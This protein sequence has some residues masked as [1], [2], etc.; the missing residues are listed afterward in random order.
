[1][2]HVFKRRSELG[3]TSATLRSDR[4]KKRNL[5]CG[6]DSEVK[7]GE[8]WRSTVCLFPKKLLKPRFL[9]GVRNWVKRRRRRREDGVD[10]LMKCATDTASI[11][12]GNHLQ[13][14]E[15]GETRITAHVSS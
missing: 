10:H 9:I 14:K 13:K 5:R 11:P 1:M 12:N 7:I 6:G 8:V 4:A 3:V 15:G 2:L